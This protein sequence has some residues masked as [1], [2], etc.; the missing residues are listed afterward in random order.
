MAILPVIALKTDMFVSQALIII[1]DVII[2]ILEDHLFL[3]VTLLLLM[4]IIFQ[5]AFVL[6]GIHVIIRMVRVM[7]LVKFIMK[8]LLLNVHL[9]L[10]VMM[11]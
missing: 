10:S 11:T 8:Q 5:A 1:M 6:K 9:V 2:V 7:M 4:G 3:V